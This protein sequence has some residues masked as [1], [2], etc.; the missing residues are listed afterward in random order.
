MT[1]IKQF[2]E[3]LAEKALFA[4]Q[5]HIFQNW[6]AL[7]A[8]QQKKLLIQAETIDFEALGRLTREYIHTPQN[9]H[10]Q[11]HIESVKPISIPKTSAEI[12]LSQKMVPIGEKALRNGSVGVLLVAGG[13]GSRLGFDGPKG[14]FPITPVKQK[15]LFQLHAEKILALN[16][17]YETRIPFYIMTS[18]ANHEETK[19]FFYTHSYFGLPKTDVFFFQ[20]GMLPALD[21]N[22]KLILDAPGHLFMNPNGHGGVFEALSQSGV[23]ADLD[24]RGIEYIFYFQVDNVLIKM[25]DPVFLGHHIDAQA[26]MSSKVCA[27]RDAYEKVGVIGKIDGKL[28]VIEYSDMTEADKTAKDK[29]G[30][31]L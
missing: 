20:Q 8:D 17:R 13:Q 6:E 1:N 7:S 4:G 12:N 10:F 23:L 22:G 21:A 27:K 18:E 14:K 5:S 3:K 24:A 25:C 2:Y 31:L 29:N 28:G 30:A 26:E 19:Q 15:S 11:G 9:R 16:R